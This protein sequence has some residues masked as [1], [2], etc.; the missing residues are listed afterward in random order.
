M[1]RKLL[2]SLFQV[3]ILITRLWR[4]LVYI[5]NIYIHLLES[6]IIQHPDIHG[7]QTPRLRKSAACFA[8]LR[9]KVYE[10]M[11]NLELGL[12]KCRAVACLMMFDVAILCHPWDESEV[13][14]FEYVYSPYSLGFWLRNVMQLIS[15][16]FVTLLAPREFSTPVFWRCC[17]AGECAVEAWPNVCFFQGK[18]GVVKSGVSQG[19][20]LSTWGWYGMVICLILE[21]VMR[22]KKSRWDDH[23]HVCFLMLVTPFQQL[24]RCCLV[25]VSLSP[26]RLL[27]GIQFLDIILDICLLDHLHQLDKH[28]LRTSVFFRLELGI[29]KPHDF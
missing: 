10:A 19:L 5:Y 23:Y 1:L 27:P 20:A 9:G 12:G 29:S 2:N 13:L 3:N 24:S 22:P 7:V 14:G 15:P 26:S 17:C 16:I 6:K 25:F 18:V 8:L 21:D 11:E 4:R 28:V